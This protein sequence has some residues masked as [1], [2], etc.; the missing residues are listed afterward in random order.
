MYAGNTGLKKKDLKY[1]K[2]IR[3]RFYA[4]LNN[5]LPR[6]ERQKSF[7]YSF[8]GPITVKEVIESMKVPPAE[9]DLILVNGKSVGF[10]YHVN[11][12]DYIS[13]YPVFEHFNISSVSMLRK[14]P[15]RIT[16]FILDAHLGKLAKY[17]RMF[18]FDTLYKN[19]Y[20]DKT[21][22]QTAAQE[23]RIIL[24]R[25]RDLLN[26]K[27]VTHGYYVRSIDP[28]DQLTEIMAKFD[29]YPQAKP[30]S[31]CLNCNN[32]LLSINK[33]EI[34]GLIDPDT[35]RIYNEFFKCM[36][37]DKI[38]WKGSHYQHMKEFMEEN[39]NSG[40]NRKLYLTKDFK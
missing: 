26:H 39:T 36:S 14:V 27:D 28:K 30:F 33:E 37:C 23:S 7:Y 31:R 24:T 16:R 1:Y 34:A 17:L 5:F 3:L 32:V 25:D 12:S 35:F 21:I 15:L 13:V 20:P 4:E 40:Q 22:R 10:D 18:G 29:L 11:N 9:V 38:F 8:P 2:S 6:S 19:D